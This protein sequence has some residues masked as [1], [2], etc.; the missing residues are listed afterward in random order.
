MCSLSY[1]AALFVSEDD[2]GNLMEILT[3]VS[4]GR[5]AELQR[6]GSWLYEQF[7]SSVKAI[8]LTTLDIINDRVFP[9]SARTYQDWNMPSD[10]VSTLI[11]VSNSCI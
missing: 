5:I 8:T 4:D 11:Y 3:S 9:Q 6:Q 7:L 10:P 2:L 1:R